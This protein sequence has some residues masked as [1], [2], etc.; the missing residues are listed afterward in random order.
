MSSR[1][2]QKKAAQV[3]RAQIAREKRRTRTIITSI[4]AVVLLVI[5]GL[6]GWTVYSSQKSKSFTSPPNANHTGTGIVLG[7]GPVTI[8]LYEDYLCPVCKQFQDTSGPTITQLINENKVRVVYHPVAFLNRFSST[9]YSTRSAAASGC[10]AQGAR[11][12]EFTDALFAK[13]PPENSA[14]LSDNELIDIGASVGVNRDAMSSCVRDGTYK[15]WTA[16]V[17]DDAAK[18]GVTGTPTVK[19]NGKELTDR[20]P[21]GIKAAVA[22]AGK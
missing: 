14:G 5:A 19:V 12:K 11:F 1:K 2:G 8:D 22:A 10:A 20:S 21:E 7:Q 4:A 17:T 18:S 3:V 6:I 15:T 13:Q 16:H 9:Q